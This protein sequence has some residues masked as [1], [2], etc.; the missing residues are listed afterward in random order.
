MKGYTY[1]TEQEAIDARDLVDTY[2]G[3]PK[4]GCI[5]QNWCEYKQSN[6]FFYIP[7]DESLEVVLGT[8]IEIILTPQTPLF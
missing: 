7:Y 2:Y 1:T 4:D 8:P 6:N 3:Y 5:T